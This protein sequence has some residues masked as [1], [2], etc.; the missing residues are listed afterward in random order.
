MLHHISVVVINFTDKLYNSLQSLYSAKE[1]KK[2]LSTLLP[3]R[4]HVIA[5]MN[6]LSISIAFYA[7][8]QIQYKI[9]IDVLINTRCLILPVNNVLA[10]Y[11]TAPTSTDYIT[12]SSCRGTESK[13][14]TTFVNVFRVLA[15]T[16]KRVQRKK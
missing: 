11:F 10:K 5:S 15:H 12:S 6:K 16:K 13:P 2:D 14:S 7:H 3:L 8:W 9:L 4:A 1:T